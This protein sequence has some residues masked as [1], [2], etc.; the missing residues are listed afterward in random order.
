MVTK[1]I[2]G[3]MI[4]PDLIVKKIDEYVSKNGCNPSYIV[5][6][7]STLSMLKVAYAQYVRVMT[8]D[9]YVEFYGIPVS[10]CNRVR[11]GE[12]EIV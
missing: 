11:I 12:F 2:T 6:S 10:T 9:T 5:M 7:Y 4:S 8:D 1:K 3:V